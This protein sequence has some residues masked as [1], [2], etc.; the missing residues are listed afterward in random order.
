MGRLKISLFF[1]LLVAIALFVLAIAVLDRSNTPLKN[2]KWRNQK[3]VEL[4]S[5]AIEDTTVSFP[6]GFYT[7]TGHLEVS[8]PNSAKFYV[9][10]DDCIK[11]IKVNQIAVDIPQVFNKSPICI[12]E[13]Y[14]LANFSRFV[15]AGD[16]EISFLIENHRGYV[17]LLTR[18]YNDNFYSVVIFLSFFISFFILLFPFLE[19][20]K[21]SKLDQFIFYLATAS[22]LAYF[23][24]TSWDQ[25]SYDVN[26]HIEYFLKMMRDFRLFASRECWE[27]S[28]QP[29]YYLLVLGVY[30]VIAPFLLNSFTII[31]VLQLL[32][33]L[34]GLV[35]FV[36]VRLVLKEVG[37]KNQ[38]LVYLLLVTWL[39]GFFHF[40]RIGNDAPWYVFG[41]LCCLFSLRWW[42]S[43][44]INNF[45]W[46]SFYGICA[47]AIKA[48]ALYLVGTLFVLFLIRSFH[49]LRNYSDSSLQK[50][51]LVKRTLILSALILASSTVFYIK[52]LLTG[53]MFL[54]VNAPNQRLKVS[55]NL[56]DYIL[57]SPNKF[58]T[59]SAAFTWDPNS[60]RHLFLN[61]VSKSLLHGEFPITNPFH[62]ELGT[63]QDL[64]F[65]ILFL[66]M[67]YLIYEHQLWRVNSS[68]FP[69]LLFV[70]VAMLTLASYRY[71]YPFSSNQDFRYIYP[72]FL[73]AGVF[74]Y[75]NKKWINALVFTL[76]CIHVIFVWSLV[77]TNSY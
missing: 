57:F 21:F 12:G 13:G 22:L 63:L 68:V 47:L 26:G 37:G 39:S 19:T 6:G 62:K 51:F 23:M 49:E 42:N 60:G 18:S 33:V 67:V 5:F 34:F 38:S 40:A 72:V 48:S 45:I 17:S 9:R 61:F 36:L 64:L 50:V 29:T 77:A 52:P 75:S 41:A 58:F 1:R 46:A 44:K 27:C 24:S 8:D 59:T 76:A 14:I 69:M 70:F 66:L 43:K 20:L 54:K 56:S 11:G 10:V 4:K 16:N 2:L 65:V 53:D 73:L 71:R 74:S 35:F 25:R 55:N 31:Q 3:T 15:K 32:Q 30:K 7:F 28:Q